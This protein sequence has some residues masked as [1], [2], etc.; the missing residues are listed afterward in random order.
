MCYNIEGLNEGVYFWKALYI[1][2]KRKAG[3]LLDNSNIMS[4][5][6]PAGGGKP[7]TAS[8]WKQPTERKR[9][10]K[11][12]V[13]L[14]KDHKTQAYL[15]GQGGEWLSAYLQEKARVR[16]KGPH[17]GLS[18]GLSPQDPPP[19]QQTFNTGISHH[20]VV[21]FFLSRLLELVMNSVHEFS[22]LF[23]CSY[24]PTVLAP[25]S[26]SSSGL[27]IDCV[28]PPLPQLVKAQGFGM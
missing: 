16:I 26:K 13:S 12:I 23:H 19:P 22:H 10:K 1:L 18:Q 5:L 8:A 25:N 3:M 4:T 17:L 11:S 2:L 14:V 27:A 9:R 24:W 6:P 15:V 7:D 21:S 28:S 20:F